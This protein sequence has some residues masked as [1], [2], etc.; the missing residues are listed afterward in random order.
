VMGYST[1]GSVVVCLP[2]DY[3]V[4]TVRNALASRRV[5]AY[6]P[7]GRQVKGREL[8]I[9]GKLTPRA[10]SELARLGWQVHGDAGPQLGVAP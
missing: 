2:V 1:R 8:R 9:T 3:A 10:A 5:S 6:L 7:A 4:W